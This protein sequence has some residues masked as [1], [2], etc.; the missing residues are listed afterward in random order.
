MDITVEE[1][2]RKLD[3][4]EEFIFIDVREVHEYQ[5]SNL[6]AKLIPLGVLPFRLHEFEANKNDEIVVH[7]RSGARSGQAKEMMK[8]EGF[9]NVRNLLGGILDWQAKI[10]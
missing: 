9:T 1:L 6:N 4:G 8:K 2:K 10:K 7:C 3:A 5:E